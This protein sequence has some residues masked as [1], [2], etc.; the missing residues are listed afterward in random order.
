MLAETLFA[1]GVQKNNVTIIPDE[2][3]AVSAV[4]AM[5]RPRDLVLI[6]GDSIK[7]TWRQI[8][9][10]RPDVAHARAESPSPVRID[11]G[12]I[13]ELTFGGDAL[14]RDERVVR[15]AREVDD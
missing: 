12:E 5:A 2:Q 7:R 13:P 15:L 14:L 11:P 10:F 8:T 6:F 3:E 9:S 1:S 4:L